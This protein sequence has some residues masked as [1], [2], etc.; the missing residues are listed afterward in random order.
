MKLID[1][2]TLRGLEDEEYIERTIDLAE[3][4]SVEMFE[5]VRD[6][7]GANDVHNFISIFSGFLMARGMASMVFNTK[8]EEMTLEQMK[9]EVT[10]EYT[11]IS[12]SVL[13]QAMEIL[14]QTFNDHKKDNTKTRKLR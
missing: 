6:E 7:E 1:I 11:R 10:A 5:Q 14:E 2:E 4:C 3:K 9:V 12:N 8:R 13:P